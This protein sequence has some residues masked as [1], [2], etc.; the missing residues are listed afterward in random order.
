M[1]PQIL[2]LPPDSHRPP[3]AAPINIV[4]HVSPLYSSMQK[5]THVWTM[6]VPTI[7]NLTLVVKIFDP[8]Y[9]SDE[10]SKFTDPFSFLAM[11]VSHEVAAYLH[12]QNTNVPRFHSHFLMPILL[13]GDKTMHVL[14][15]EHIDGKDFH[16]LVP[17][18]K[19]KDGCHA[20]KLVIINMALNL[21]LDTFIFSQG[22]SSCGTLDA[23]L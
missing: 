5:L 7:F 3:P 6:H 12:L 19:A 14:L 20:H 1:S 8:T 17:V 16:V 11:S 13:Q 18:Q 4:L 22:M 23:T 15:I 21:N 9:M 10:S 2:G